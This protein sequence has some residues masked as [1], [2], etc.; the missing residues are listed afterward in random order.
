MK[1]KYLEKLAEYKV[2]AIIVSDLFIIDLVKENN[3]DLKI[4][5]STQGC[6]L[7]KEAVL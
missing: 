4:H 5:I 7:N 6:T 3:I 2:D 1:Q